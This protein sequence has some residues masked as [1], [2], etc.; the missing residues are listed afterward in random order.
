VLTLRVDE[1]LRVVYFVMGVQL[2]QLVNVVVGRPT[3]AH[4]GRSGVD[5]LLDD[6]QEGGRVPSLNRNDETT[7]AAAFDP[8]EEPLVCGDAL[9]SMILRAGEDGLVDFDGRSTG[10]CN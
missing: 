7:V 4:D 10:T 1:L 8:S 9:P 3:V 5:V 6:R 2:R